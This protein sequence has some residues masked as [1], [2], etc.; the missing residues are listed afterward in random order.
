MPKTFRE[1]VGEAK[2]QIREIAPEAVE[3]MK[4]EGEPVL[5]LDVREGEDYAEGHLPG[6]VSLPRGF[7]ELNIDEHTTDEERPIVLYCGGGSRSALSAKSLQEMGYRN[8]MSL[9]GGFRGWKESGREVEGE[10]T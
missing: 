8:V 1:V 2:E 10:G 6:A 3:R 7:L 9:T 4:A 5:I